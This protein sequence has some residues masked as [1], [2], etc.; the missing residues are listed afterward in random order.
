MKVIILAGGG[1]TRLFPMSRTCYPKQFLEFAGQ[2]S[3][4]AQTVERFLLLVKPSDIVVVTNQA[5]VYFVKAELESVGAVDASV[6]CEPAA[7]NTAPAIA[8]AMKYCED[9]LGL[10]NTEIMFVAPSD[11]IIRPNNEFALLVRRAEKAAQKGSI[12]TLGVV[13]D[14]PET[15]YGYIYA[16]KGDGDCFD[17][18]SFR[19]KPDVTTA[20]KYIEDG[21]Y[22]W[23]AGM[24]AFSALTM[25]CELQKYAPDVMEKYNADYKEMLDAFS[26]MPS[27][28]IDYAVMEKSSSVKM[29]PLDI[30]WNDIGSWDAL[31]ESFDADT[32]GNVSNGECV[33]IDCKNTMLI[34]NTRLVAAIGLENINVIETPDVILVAAKGQSQKVKD[35]VER[36][37]I[38]NNACVHENLTMYRPWGCYTI[39]SEGEG[40]K[41]KKITVNPG[42]K[43]SLQMHYHRS[44]HWTVIHGTGKLTVNDKEVFFK[45]NESAYIPIASKHRLENPG[46]LPLVIIEVQNGRYLGEDDIV[47]FDDEYGRL[48]K[49]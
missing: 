48:E 44:E 37:K 46:T 20:Q 33:S 5:Y 40:Y 4:L 12:V 47:R 19:E 13:P 8:L 29:L 38:C 26:E 21:N 18:V 2:K 22:F 28:S 31:A 11:H 10:D 3:L 32:E 49:F 24:F 17:V 34:S 30:Y 23:N 41:V 1:G 6:V 35:L 14:K 39:L 27:I 7:R 45:E 42:C 9:T 43:L 36:L 15:G 25:K 16:H